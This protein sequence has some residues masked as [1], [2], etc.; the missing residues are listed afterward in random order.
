MDTFTELQKQLSSDPSTTEEFLPGLIHKSSQNSISSP[1]DLKVG[2]NL[3]NVSRKEIFDLKNDFP[4]LPASTTNLNVVSD[5]WISRINAS[6]KPT[7]L[8]NQNGNAST[9]RFELPL[10][11]QVH[12]L[13]K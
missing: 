10:H 1:P 7:S 9:L 5:A 8:Q 13:Y 3:E 2:L 11:L 12:S 6:S 4:S